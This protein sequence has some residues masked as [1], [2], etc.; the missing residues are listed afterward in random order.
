M[1]VSVAGFWTS[2]FTQANI[3]TEI[4]VDP[5]KGFTTKGKDGKP[6]VLLLRKALYG[7][8]QAARLWQQA[9]IAKLIDMGFKGGLRGLGGAVP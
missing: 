7:T 4:Y 5:P 2:A 3:D 9:L 6:K 8:K 1:C